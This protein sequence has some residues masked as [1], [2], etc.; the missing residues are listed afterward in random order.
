[1]SVDSFV[2]AVSDVNGFITS[3]KGRFKVVHIEET[4]EGM[5]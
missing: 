3:T 4:D 5:K 2:T 1:M